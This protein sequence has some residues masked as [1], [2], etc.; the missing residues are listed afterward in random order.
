MY[1][2]PQLLPK[3][4]T[5]DSIVPA[6][7]TNVI[8]SQT[9][10]SEPPKKKSLFGKLKGKKQDD[11]ISEKGLLKVVMMPRREYQKYFAKDLNGVYIGTE[12][13]RRWTEEE[14]EETFG[15]YKPEKVE[16]KRKPSFG[17]YL[18]GMSHGLR[19]NHV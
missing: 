10:L 18:D 4:Y 6:I 9:T 8:P 1:L 7:V 15:K 14:L 16:K 3:R 17:S 2:P 12:P 5:D 11:R 13:Y 19:A